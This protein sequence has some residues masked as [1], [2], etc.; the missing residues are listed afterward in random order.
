MGSKRKAVID[1]VRRF[2]RSVDSSVRIRPSQSFGLGIVPTR[3]NE[4]DSS[5]PNISGF[6]RVLH[7][8]WRAFLQLFEPNV[9][10]INKKD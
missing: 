3:H 1:R 7:S 8:M 4:P 10:R 5:D 6:R 2:A 9:M